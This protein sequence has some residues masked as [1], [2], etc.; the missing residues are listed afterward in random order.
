[1]SKSVCEWVAVGGRGGE[2]VGQPERT[3]ERLRSEPTG[4]ITCGQKK[5]DKMIFAKNC[6]L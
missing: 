3:R 1:M 5:G 4:Q 2:G 6:G